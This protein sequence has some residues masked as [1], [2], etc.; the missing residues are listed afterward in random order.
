MVIYLWHRSFKGNLFN[1]ISI[2][3]CGFRGFLEKTL[4]AFISKTEHR[5]NVYVASP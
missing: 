5:L 1:L 4:D 2:V 3:C